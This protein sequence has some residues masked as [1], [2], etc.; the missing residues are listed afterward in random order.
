MMTHCI[1]VKWNSLVSDKKAMLP[2]INNIFSKLKTFNEIHDVKLL[3]NVI[4][5][6][7]RYDLMI[8]IK[9]DKD[10]LTIYDDSSKSK[11]ALFSTNFPNLSFH[12]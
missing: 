8:C 5:R 4:D 11:I 12:S 7:N 9:L 2:E 1:L 3:E 6:S 10:L